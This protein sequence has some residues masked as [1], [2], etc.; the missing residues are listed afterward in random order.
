MVKLAY[1]FVLT[2]LA[3]G[4]AGLRPI[5]PYEQAQ[6]C[7]KVETLLTQ[8]TLLMRKGSAE[9]LN[10]AESALHLARDLSPH[11]AR[12]IDGLG[13]IALRRHDYAAAKNQFDEAIELDSNYDRPYAHLAQIAEHGGRV[14]EAKQLLLKALQLNPLN[15][16]SR[17][18]YAVLL[19]E[20]AGNE[21][22]AKEAYEEMLKAAHS[23]P[24]KEALLEHNARVMRRMLS[25][26]SGGGSR[27]Q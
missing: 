4:C 14:G 2:V 22:E 12:V 24:P 1:C 17:N 11:N 21:T 19:A 8:A 7:R 27:K 3:A 15:Y 6:R 20:L 13:C 26:Y 5:S 16:R 23:G 25:V 9:E 18:N 10:S